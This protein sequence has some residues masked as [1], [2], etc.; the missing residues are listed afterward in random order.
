MHLGQV[1]AD[2]YGVHQLKSSGA[3]LPQ[4]VR[5]RSLLKST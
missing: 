2:R 1:A 4:I 3:D 5:L